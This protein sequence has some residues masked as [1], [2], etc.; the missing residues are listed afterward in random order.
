MTILRLAAAAALLAGAAAALAQQQGQKPVSRTDYLKNIDN[1]FAS[2]DAN[3]DGKVS[4]DEMVVAQQADLKKARSAIQQQ[5]EAKFKQLDTNKDGQLSLAEFLGA[6]PTLR[7][8]ETPDQMIQRFDSNRDGKVTADE[9]RAPQVAAFNAAD[10]NHDN[11]IS[12]AEAQAYARS[13]PAN[14]AQPR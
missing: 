1:R 13:H 14:G 4:R 6:T 11:V 3:H 5:L 9:F 8:G 10:T 12:P 7:T 2:M